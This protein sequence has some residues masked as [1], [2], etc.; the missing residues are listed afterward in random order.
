MIVFNS[1]EYLNLPR[2][3]VS[4]FMAAFI[5]SREAAGTVP[6]WLASMAMNTGYRYTLNIIS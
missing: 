4:S 2:E 5:S 3:Y 6:A 1:G